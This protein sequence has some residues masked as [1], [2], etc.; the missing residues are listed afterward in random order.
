[1]LHDGGEILR[2]GVNGLHARFHPISAGV[3]C[4][5]AQNVKF[6]KFGNINAPRGM[7]LLDIYISKFSTL[8]SFL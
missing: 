6:T 3:G 8:L 7:P 4:D 2:E 5:T 1:M